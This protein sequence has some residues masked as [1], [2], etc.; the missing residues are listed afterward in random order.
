MH[1]RRLLSIKNSAINVRNRALL[2]LIRLTVILDRPRLTAWVFSLIPG[3]AEAG[4]GIRVLC[5]GRSIFTDDIEAMKAYGGRID[6]PIVHL[7]YFYVLYDYFTD[8]QE[9]KSITESN[10]HAADFCKAGK[11]EYRDYLRKMMPWLLRYLKFDA[12][13]SGNI[14]YVVQQEFAVVCEEFNVPFIVLHKE[15]VVVPAVYGNFLAIYRH[16]HFKGSKALFYNRQCMQGL[17]DLNIP[18]LTQDKVEL[19]GIPRLDRYFHANANPAIDDNL[20]VMFSFIPRFSCRFLTSDEKLLE[21]I[22]RRGQEFFAAVMRYAAKHPEKRLIIKTKMAAQY[23]EYPKRIMSSL[24]PEGL[25]NVQIVNSGDPSELIGRASVVIGFNST[26]LIEAILAGKKIVSPDFSDIFG[27]QPWSFFD[28]H[29]G[30]VSYVKTVEDLD[31]IASSSSGPVRHDVSERND[32][33]ETFISTATGG[34]SK[35]VE[36]AIIKTVNEYRTKQAM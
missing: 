22:D 25:P 17:L 10:Y 11:L 4:K 14:G 31:S 3:R 7:Q 9:R 32:F 13:I 1:S 6:Y 35:R 15:A 26:T 16:H 36:E 5:F 24:F 8:P 33:L 18:G 19:T 20:I 34:A 27:D 28:A 29:P 30:L 23:P 21:A 12:A 2:S